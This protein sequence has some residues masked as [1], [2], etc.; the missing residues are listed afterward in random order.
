MGKR[1][2]ETRMLDSA[3]ALAS[4][5]FVAVIPVALLV[6]SFLPGGQTFAERLVTGLQL[7]GAGRLAAERLFATPDVVRAGMTVATCLVGAWSLM[8]CGGVLQRSYRSAWRLETLGSGSWRRDAGRRLLWAAGLVVYVGATFGLADVSAHGVVAI[9]RDGARIA[10]ALAFFSW[11]PYVVLGRQVAPRR[12]LPTAIAAAVALGA[13][14]AVAPLYL[15]E[16]ASAS[17][18]SYGLVGFAFAFLTWLFV[19]AL[20]IVGAAVAGA[21][22]GERVGHRDRG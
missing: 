20:L 2:V 18:R 6:S 16:V 3:L 11:G 1:A 17:A 5:L 22:I 8:S 10:L 21:V 7:Q 12:L 14:A 15:P 9:V 13:V 4:R 19:Q